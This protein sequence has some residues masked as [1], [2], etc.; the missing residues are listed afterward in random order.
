M[1]RIKKTLCAALCLL[2]LFG[3]GCW[4][5][6]EPKELAIVHSIIYDMTDEG[7]IKIITEIMDPSGG[8]NGGT[9]G[10]GGNGDAG[11]NLVMISEGDSAREALSHLSK[12]VEKN[13]FGG[14]NKVRFFTEPFAKEGHII[15]ML[16]FLLRD[17]LTDE[18]PLMIVIKG[19]TPEDVHFSTAGLSD[20]VGDYFESLKQKQPQHTSKSVFVTTLDFLKDYLIEGKQPVAGVAEIMSHPNTQAQDEDG[21]GGGSGGQNGEGG[22]GGQNG[23]G[24]TSQDEGGEKIILYEGLAAFKEGKLVGY[25]DGIE[26]RAYNI[27]VNDVGVSFFSIPSGDGLTVFKISSSSADT[28]ASVSSEQIAFHVSIQM[29]LN[30]IEESGDKDL[31]EQAWL[32]YIEKEFNEAMKKEIDAAIK[33][34][35]QEFRSDIFGFG[36]HVHRQ[37][38]DKWRALKYNW[39]D[40]FAEATV[41]VTVE[42]TVTRTGQIKQPL[43]RRKEDE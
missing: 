16:D 30:I 24:E 26:A 39:D 14:H 11:P 20:L 27:L 1:I 22:S 33:K 40:Y 43:K 5:K 19:E 41:Y 13:V 8:G 42:S 10:G 17:H 34:A 2:L 7:K 9:M 3:G 4:D 28:K 25:M 15:S 12:H 21:E 29:T 36:R 37:L 31:T 38:P 18:T 32:D 23:G 35:Q 6:K